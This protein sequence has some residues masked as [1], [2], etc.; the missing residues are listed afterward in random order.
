MLVHAFLVVA[1]TT[2]VSDAP[3]PTPIPCSAA[4]HRHFDFWVGTWEVRGPKGQVAGTNR[5]ESILKRCGLHE[6]WS[7]AGGTRGESFGDRLPRGAGA[8]CRGGFRRRVAGA[9]GGVRLR[10]AARVWPALSVRRPRR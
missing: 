6:S 7:G 8:G 9:G 5:I 4:E 2:A 10:P 1:A 3:T